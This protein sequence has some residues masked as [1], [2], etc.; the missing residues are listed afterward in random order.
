[1]LLP[2]TVLN[3]SMVLWLLFA[4]ISICHLSTEN[5]KSAPME[6]PVIFKSFQEKKKNY[7]NGW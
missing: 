5:V 6:C 1:M 4:E 7:Q 2:N 3:I